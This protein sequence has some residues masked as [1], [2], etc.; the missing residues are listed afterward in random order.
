MATGDQHVTVGFEEIDRQPREKPVTDI[1]PLRHGIEREGDE[2]LVAGASLLSVFE[3]SRQ[4]QAANAVALMARGYEQLGQKPQV[5]AHPAQSEAEHLSF[6]L[7]HPQ[8][9][10]IVAQRELLEIGRAQRGHRAKAVAFGK[11]VDAANDQ[12]FGRLQFV[13]ARRPAHRLHD[14]NF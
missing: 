10:W 1:Q 3:G 7:R 11:I 6:G 12:L 8:A 2:G 5:A 14:M 9:V 4:Q 13:G